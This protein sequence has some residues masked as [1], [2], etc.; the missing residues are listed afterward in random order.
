[1][2]ERI[3][4]AEVRRW[5]DVIEGDSTGVAYALRHLAT[6]MDADEQERDELAVTNELFADC[7]DRARRM[8]QKAHPDKPLVW[9]DGATNIVWLLEQ[10]DALAAKVQ[11]Y[12]ARLK[13]R[14]LVP[15]EYEIE[16]DG[17]VSA[18]PTTA[19]GNAYL[20]PGN[21]VDEAEALVNLQAAI[22]EESAN[23]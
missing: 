9:P 14:V 4:A 16:N 7:M 5:V 3:S 21:G 22:D 1:M 18:F 13:G 11:E 2:P 10:H 20:Y 6:Q 19:I 17:T 15:V 8:W 23:G 12:E